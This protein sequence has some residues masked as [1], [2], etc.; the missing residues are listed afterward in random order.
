[1]LKDETIFYKSILGEYPTYKNYGIDAPYRNL[2]IPNL[3]NVDDP[4]DLNYA[5]ELMSEIHYAAE[6]Y[7]RLNENNMEELEIAITEIDL[8]RNHNDRLIELLH[9][10]LSDEELDDLEIITMFTKFMTIN[11]IKSRT[12]DKF[13]LY[14]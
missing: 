2:K 11:K 9:S 5:N 13:K 12:V 1:M 6:E 8:L 3:V 7:C 4:D 14:L 10:R